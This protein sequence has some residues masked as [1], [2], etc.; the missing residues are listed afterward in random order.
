MGTRF[1]TIL[2]GLFFV[3][4]VVCDVLFADADGVQGDGYQIGYQKI[5][6]E[7]IRAEEF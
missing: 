6:F 4:L 1:I 5:R 3:S 2:L 7:N